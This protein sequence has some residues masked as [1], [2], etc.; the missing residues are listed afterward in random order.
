[1]FDVKNRKEILALTAFVQKKKRRK[2]AASA[3][4]DAYRDFFCVERRDYQLFPGKEKDFF[5]GENFYTC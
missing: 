3:S 2:E 4:R 1:M 5:F